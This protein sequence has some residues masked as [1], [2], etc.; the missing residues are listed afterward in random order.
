MSITV[1]SS[2]Q[3]ATLLSTN[4]TNGNVIKQTFTDLLPNASIQYRMNQTRNLSLNYSASTTQPSTSQL[5]P[6]SDVSDPLNTNTGNPNL[7]R[8]Y[9]QSVN[10]NYFSTNIY[11]Q[12]NFFAFIAMS[13]TNNAIV[14]ADVIQNNGSRISMPVHADGN[15][16]VFG[17]VNAGFPLTKLKS[18]I[19][20]GIG[21]NMIHNISFVDGARNEIDNVSLSP[22]L[23]YSFGLDNKIDINTT[24][25]P[26]ISKAK[27]S[28]QPLLNGSYLQQV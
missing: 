13:K 22:N 7:K 19:D 3:E 14:N 24:S 17:N 9:A 25:R 11:T 2:L 26:N 28:L 27:Y 10:L 4:N 20:L 6:V 18:R 8:S 21:S 15:Y 16:M 23:G 12:T 5:Q 1:G